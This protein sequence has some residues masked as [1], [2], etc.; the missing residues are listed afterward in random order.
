M[1]KWWR[2][3][4]GASPFYGLEFYGE[5]QKLFTT[6]V[7][8]LMKVE[9]VRK[10]DVFFNDRPLQIPRVEGVYLSRDILIESPLQDN[11]VRIDEEPK[12]PFGDCLEETTVP[13][14]L[15]KKTEKNS[16]YFLSWVLYERGCH[17]SFVKRTLDKEEVIATTGLVNGII[18]SGV[19]RQWRDFS[20]SVDTLIQLVESLEILKREKDD[21]EDIVHNGKTE[22]NI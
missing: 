6:G 14:L 16:S 9:A 20:A 4:D 8:H 1:A 18:S 3:K 12:S 17:L 10:L 13:L 15:L 7:L 11:D 2:V 21:W 5:E 22:K 19:L